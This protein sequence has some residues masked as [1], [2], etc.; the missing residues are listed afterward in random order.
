MVQSVDYEKEIEVGW[1]VKLISVKGKIYK[2]R[3]VKARDFLMHFG[4]KYNEDFEIIAYPNTFP[5]SPSRS[6][7]A[8]LPSTSKHQRNHPRQS[9]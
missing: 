2:S 1:P 5:T 7:A 4:F 9:Q 6:K 3:N 8:Q